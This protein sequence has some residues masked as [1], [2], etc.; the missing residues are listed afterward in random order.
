M[1][2]NF[3]RFLLMGGLVSLAGC[4]TLGYFDNSEFIEAIN[5]KPKQCQTAYRMLAK[6][7]T[8]S[9][10]A[11]TH[12]GIWELNCGDRERGQE[13]LS[14]AAMAGDGYAKTILVNRGLPL[15]EPEIYRS[16]GGRPAIDVYINK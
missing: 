1:Y 10:D 3:K 9:T 13:F 6:T 5:A 7:F 16:T 8:G 4:A 2:R 11:I 15:P 12:R 14:R